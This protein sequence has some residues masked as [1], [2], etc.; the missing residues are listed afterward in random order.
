MKMMPAIP[1]IGKTFP[2][3]FN[4]AHNTIKL[5]ID[6]IRKIL[7]KTDAEDNYFNREN[8]P[9]SLTIQSNEDIYFSKPT[10]K[11]RYFMHLKFDIK[12]PKLKV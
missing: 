12:V 9:G 10:F 8:S 4:V 7:I 3:F 6:S 2:T 5:P 1:Y 11:K